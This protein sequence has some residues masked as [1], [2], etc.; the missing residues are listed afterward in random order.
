M[1]LFIPFLPFLLTAEVEMGAC[2]TQ[3]QVLLFTSVKGLEVI[4][5]LGAPQKPMGKHKHK[6]KASTHF[7]IL[8]V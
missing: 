6:D 2:A 5:K 4:P 7:H 8:F 1:R 3:L